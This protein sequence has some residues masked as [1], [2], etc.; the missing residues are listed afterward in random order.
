MSC[1]KFPFK[2]SSSSILSK[3]TAR[4]HFLT[5]KSGDSFSLSCCCFKRQ[6]KQFQQ[7]E[8]VTSRLEQRM[9]WWKTTPINF[10]FKKFVALVSLCR[11]AHMSTPFL[12]CCCWPAFFS[13]QI[14]WRIEC[15]RERER[16]RWRRRVATIFARSASWLPP[17]VLTV[18]NE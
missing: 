5:E 12:Y 1:F 2:D 16:G 17:S 11:L 18:E 6:A 13:S 4:G 7:A 3:Y 8:T 14:F 15:R 9:T 10:P